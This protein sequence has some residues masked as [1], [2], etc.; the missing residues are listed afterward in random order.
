MVLHLPHVE[1]VFGVTFNDITKD[2][3]FYTSTSR[4][5]KQMRSP[6]TYFQD[7]HIFSKIN[8]GIHTSLSRPPFK[9]GIK[10]F[11]SSGRPKA[12]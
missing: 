11:R 12:T 2:D 10:V 3:G 8:L 4:F 7:T 9:D 1:G 5:Q 6:N